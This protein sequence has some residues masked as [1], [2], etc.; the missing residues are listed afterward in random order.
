MTSVYTVVCTFGL[1]LATGWD[2]LAWL[3]WGFIGNWIGGGAG[4]LLALVGCV[5]R[6]RRRALAVRALWVNLV[7]VAVPVILMLIPFWLN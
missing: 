2:Q 3:V 6:S 1:F 7:V 4:F 5:Q